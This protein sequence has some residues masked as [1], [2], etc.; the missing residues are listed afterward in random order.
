MN[1][2]SRLVPWLAA[3]LA[4]LALVFLGLRLLLT[5]VFLQ[6]EYRMPG[7]PADSYGFT[8]SDR[9]RWSPYAVEF[10]V[11]D[12]GIEYLG[13]LTFDD[14]AALFN[15]RELSHMQ[16]VKD[17]VR[18]ALWVGTGSWL[19]LA[20]LGLWSRLAERGWGFR[21][22]L[23]AGGWLTVGLAAGAALFAVIGFT[24]FFTAFHS[25]FFEGD[26]WLFL[27]SDTLIR[28]FPVRFWQDCFL[29]IGLIAVGGGLA[30]GLACRE[31]RSRQA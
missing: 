13:G 31:P 4:P 1:A 16:D 14:G 3:P 19:A 23:R 22:G 10:L 7:F 26:S 28:L 12:A 5:P 18:P 24:Q 27:Y 20:G 6:V 29:Y 9:L 21:R 11:T 17:I 25:L 30:L 15:E 2:A 8:L